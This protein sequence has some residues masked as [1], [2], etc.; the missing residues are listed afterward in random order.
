MSGRTLARMV[1]RAVRVTEW[2]G[3]EVLQV[4]QDIAIPEPQ[5]TQVSPG[6]IENICDVIKYNDR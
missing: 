4:L 6:T 1:M 2:G 5:A 3:P